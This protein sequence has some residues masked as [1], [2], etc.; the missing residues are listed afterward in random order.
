MAICK[1]CKKEV[2]PEDFEKEIET[3]IECIIYIQEAECESQRQ[4]VQVTRD[5]AIDA[6]DRSLEG[7]WVEW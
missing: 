5:M 2:S 7:Q 6:G 1:E 4:M 3:C